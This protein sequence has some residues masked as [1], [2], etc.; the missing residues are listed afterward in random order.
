MVYSYSNTCPRSLSSLDLTI[1]LLLGTAV[2]RARTRL[3][4][5]FILRIGSESEGAG[6]LGALVEAIN[7]D[8]Y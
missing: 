8:A 7:V 3:R 5:R 2:E 6:D 1:A 4:P